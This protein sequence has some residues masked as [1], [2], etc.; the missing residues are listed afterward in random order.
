MDS[1]LYIVFALTAI[2]HMINTFA[3]SV[4]L[5]GVKTKRLGIALSLFNVIFLISSTANTIQGPLLSKFIEKQFVNVAIN[6]PQYA[7]GLDN[8]AEVIRIVLISGTIGTLLG[9]L[10]IPNYV[11]IFTKGI[12]IFEQVKSVPKLVLMF[13]SPKKVKR[14]LKDIYL[15]SAQV[16]TSYKYNGI[17]KKLIILN[18][19]IT[20][21]FTTGVLSAVYAGSLVPQFGK[22]ATLLASIIN[23]VAMVL[24]ATLVDPTVGMVVDQAINQERSEE[25][26]KKMV[27]FLAVSRIIGTIFAQAIF[28]PAAYIIEYVARVI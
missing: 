27:R 4:R 22:T 21:I 14:V 20:G 5:A 9:T 16:L 18:I 17:P 26:V 23:G 12:M 15:P 10:L 7:Q 13:L 19:I 3:Y 11:R 25:D 6:S 1:R 2:I 24:L 8:I 28:L